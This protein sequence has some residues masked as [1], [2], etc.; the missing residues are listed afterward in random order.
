MSE[1][2]GNDLLSP[3]ITRIGFEHYKREGL[4][5]REYFAAQVLVGL[6]ISAGDREFNDIHEAKKTCAASAV[7]FADALIAELNK[8]TKGETVG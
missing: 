6:C 7:I 3:A 8:K 1:T 4:T 5:K 2:N